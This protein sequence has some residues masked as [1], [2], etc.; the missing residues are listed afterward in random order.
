ME[1]SEKAKAARLEY[2]RRYRAENRDSINEYQRKWKKENP[3]KVKEYQNRMFEKLA[4]QYER[5]AN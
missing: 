5:E 2:M 4:E 3:E 1:M